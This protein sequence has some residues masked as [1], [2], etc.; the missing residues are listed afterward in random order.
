[1]IGKIFRYLTYSG[2]WFTVIL[3]PFHWHLRWNCFFEDPFRDDKEIIDIQFICFNIRIVID[4]GSDWIDFD[5]NNE[6]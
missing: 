2:I 6:K 4:D 5:E 1:V 3:N